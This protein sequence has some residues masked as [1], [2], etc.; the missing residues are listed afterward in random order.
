MVQRME[1]LTLL[2]PVRRLLKHYRDGIALAAAAPASMRWHAARRLAAA[3]AC[4]V[5]TRIDETV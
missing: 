5:K 4:G 3:Y 1:R 2:T